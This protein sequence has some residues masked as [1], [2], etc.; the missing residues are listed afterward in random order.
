MPIE[1]FEKNLV[2]EFP[3]MDRTLFH[4]GGTSITI[5]G[6]IVAAAILVLTWILSRI[7]Q[8]AVIRGFKIRGI[9]SEGTVS[10]TRR[11]AHYTVMI[12]GALLALRAIGIDLSALF[13]AG[14][15]FAIGL[16]FALQNIVQNFVAG[17]ILLLERSIK[18]G[19][20]LEVEGRLVKVRKMGI[21]STV[22]ATLDE[23]EIIV[24]NSVIVQSTVK[25]YTL[26]NSV[27]RLRAKVGVAYRS[28]MKLVKTTLERVANAFPS[29]LRDHAPLVVL[30]DFAASAVVWE[31]SVWI[32]NPWQMRRTLG[33][34]RESI[35]WAFQEAGIVMAYPQLDVHFDPPI[36][37][38]LQ[39][40]RA[41][42]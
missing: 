35:W 6:L 14:A 33:A 21:R 17:V 11:L 34:L 13:A 37:S 25:N 16:G 29:R 18:P 30:V 27:Y 42:S 19:D 12:V 20:V 1:R 32:D 5:G 2:V 41:M 23:E 28:D 39:G 15:V 7:L 4:V 26:A 36:E 31:V 38:A 8:R 22:A 24:P 9:K 40:R 3:F 10:A